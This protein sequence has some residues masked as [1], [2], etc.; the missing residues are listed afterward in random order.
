[1]QSVSALVV[2][3]QV[4]MMT[5]KYVTARVACDSARNIS[6]ESREVVDRA[7]VLPL[8]R[9]R[10]HCHN[11]LSALRSGPNPVFSFLDFRMAR[12]VIGANVGAHNPTL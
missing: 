7:Q 3:T 6:G 5:G 11:I 1:M 4:Y 10:V 2:S 8:C 9:T 12:V